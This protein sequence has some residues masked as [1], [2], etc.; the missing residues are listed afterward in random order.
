[1]VALRIGRVFVAGARQLAGFLV[2]FAE[3]RYRFAF[4][5]L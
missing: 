1:V 5:R 3:Q 4:A 2:R